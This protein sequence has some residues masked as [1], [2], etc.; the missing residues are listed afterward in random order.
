MS[1]VPALGYSYAR[2]FED[3]GW[4]GEQ[5][6]DVKSVVPLEELGMYSEV[7][8]TYLLLQ[9]SRVR[10]YKRA[11]RRRQMGLPP[12]QAIIIAVVSQRQKPLFVVLDTS[13]IY[14]S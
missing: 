1:I 8:R 12:R 2:M 14:E 5:L 13:C 3:A 10:D 9:L 6:M 11:E 7:D 4:T